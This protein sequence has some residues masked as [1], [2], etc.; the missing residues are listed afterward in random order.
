MKKPIRKKASQENSQ[1]IRPESI[2]PG[3]P[4]RLNRILSLA[5]V[6]SRRKADELIREG[7]IDL[8]GKTVSQQ[9]TRAVWGMDSIKVDGN[10][11]PRPSERIYLALNKPIG[12]VC[13]ARDPESRPIVYDLLKGVKQRVYSIGRLDFDTIGLLL[14]TNDGDL[15]HRL[16]HPEY[17]V[18]K[19]YKVTVKG[20][21]SDQAI[22]SLRKG[23]LLDDGFSGTARV[24]LI[25]RSGSRSIIRISLT[26]G[27]NRIVRRMMEAVE[28]PVIQL[29]RT[30]FASVELGTLKVGKY[31]FF[32]PEEV[33]RLK[34]MVGLG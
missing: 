16:T 8:N 4:Q 19:T 7:R 25:N 11:V 18:P 32:E 20:S 12:Y 1:K 14:F 29:T 31:R 30:G 22:A 5:G 26:R 3:S 15:A 28:Y 17:R 9:G 24:A 34:K 13:T 33:V 6:V 21:I 23:V 27:R 10:E 2:E